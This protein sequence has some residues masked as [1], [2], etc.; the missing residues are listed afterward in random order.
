MLQTH[1]CEEL[2]LLLKPHFLLFSYLV[3]WFRPHTDYKVC[4]D[5]WL[6]LLIDLWSSNA[7]IFLPSFLQLIYSVEEQVEGLFSLGNEFSPHCSNRFSR[8]QPRASSIS[9]KNRNGSFFSNM[10][11]CLWPSH[12]LKIYMALQSIIIC[13]RSGFLNGSSMLSCI[14]DNMVMIQKKKENKCKPV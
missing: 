7:T 6:L 3:V 1:L 14:I 12:P 9:C 2:R 10:C 5:T 13:A 8:S 4:F 11:I